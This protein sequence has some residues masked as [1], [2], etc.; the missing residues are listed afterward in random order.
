VKNEMPFIIDAIA[1]LPD[2]L[3]TIW[4][5]PEGDSDYS[6]R[7]RKIK[8]EFSAR[9][10]KTENIS[11][12]RMS[13]GERGIGQR[14][15]WEHAIRNELD[16]ERHMDYIHFN[17]VKHGYCESAIDWPFSSFHRYVKQGVYASDWGQGVSFNTNRFDEWVDVG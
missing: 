15:F 6:N 3:Y 7:W 16:Y 12:S 9:I 14:R 5:L 17:P 8:G 4:R 1:I 10:P 2:H 11:K 13:K